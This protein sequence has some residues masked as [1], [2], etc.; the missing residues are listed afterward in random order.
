MA[1]VGGPAND[2]PRAGPSRRHMES[3]NESPV[4]PHKMLMQKR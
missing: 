4:F 2:E 1:R 3:K